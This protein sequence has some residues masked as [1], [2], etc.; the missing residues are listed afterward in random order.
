M[1]G[2][3]PSDFRTS[4]VYFYEAFYLHMYYITIT[5]P[6]SPLPSL[7]YTIK[8]DPDTP[9][10]FP[11]FTTNQGTLTD[12]DLDLVYSVWTDSAGT[13]MSYPQKT[14]FVSRFVTTTSF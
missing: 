5:A 6:A 4:C 9:Y 2:L 3:L 11:A 12:S 7:S 8:I 1:R 14:F 10:N 13:T